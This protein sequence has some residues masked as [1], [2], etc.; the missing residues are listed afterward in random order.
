MNRPTVHQRWPNIARAATAIRA[1]PEAMRTLRD[2][3]R[4][5]RVPPVTSATEVLATL[6]PISASATTLLIQNSR[7]ARSSRFRS[8]CETLACALASR[9][10]RDERESGTRHGAPGRA[11]DDH[12]LRNGSR[13][14][15]GEQDAGP[16]GRK[17]LVAPRQQRQQHRAEIAA[18]I[19][20]NVLVAGRLL[21]VALTLQQTT[22]HQRI[23]AASQHVRRNFQAFLEFIEPLQAINGIAEDQDAPPLADPLQAAG[24]RALHIAEVLALHRAAR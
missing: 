2:G 24:N 5:G 14:C 23:Q 3:M 8:P 19:G 9:G 4:T 20:Q 1:A 22:L 17:V 12:G 13:F 7:L 11:I 21:A 15:V 6:E 16:F 10:S 18:A